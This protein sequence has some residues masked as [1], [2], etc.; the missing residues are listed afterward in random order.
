MNAINEL[1]VGI[2]NPVTL[3]RFS[4]P[5]QNASLDRMKSH[6]ED[7]QSRAF[8]DDFVLEDE[9]VWLPGMFKEIRFQAGRGDGA[10]CRG[11]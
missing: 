5:A 4:Q 1:L 2:G 10:I 6:P 11:S 3:Y 9:I 7:E 8:P